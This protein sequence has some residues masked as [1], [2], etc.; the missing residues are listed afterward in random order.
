MCA[1][2]KVQN[3][4]TVLRD[5]A[6]TWWERL[7]I[8]NKPQ[9]WNDMKFLM[10]EIFVNPPPVLNSNDEVHH[11][12]DQSIVIPLAMAN[13]CRIPYKRESTS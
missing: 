8:P 6:S 5:P 1:R 3:A 13:F 11:L 4:T 2:R 9:T 12:D 7:S 10:R